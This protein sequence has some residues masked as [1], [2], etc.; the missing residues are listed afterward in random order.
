[1]IDA[2]ILVKFTKN[3][4]NGT[5]ATW[6]QMRGGSANGELIRREYYP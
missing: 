4:P 1:M 5:E 2:L 3:S 6:Q